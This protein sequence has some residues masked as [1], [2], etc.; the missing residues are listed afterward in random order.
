MTADLAALLLIDARGELDSTA[1]P[2]DLDFDGSIGGGVISPS[3]SGMGGQ[4]VFSTCLSAG[5][6]IGLERKKFMP[7]SRH[8]L[9]FC[10]SAYCSMLARSR[11]YTVWETYSSQ[12]HNWCV[13]ARLSYQSCGLQAVQIRHLDIHED[14][15]VR[16]LAL[17]AF[18]DLV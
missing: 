17:H 1:R 7:E 6:R 13:K 4:Y 10:S 2:F 12:G 18:F 5:R 15:V 9:T 14:E 8:S 3:S 16:R 11:G